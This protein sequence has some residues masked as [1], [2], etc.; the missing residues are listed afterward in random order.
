MYICT[1]NEQANVI[2]CNLRNVMLLCALSSKV[3]Y[4][5]IFNIRNEI[6]P[7]Q[8]CLFVRALYQIDIPR[9]MQLANEIF[10]THF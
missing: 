5:K 7:I 3:S 8:L 9:A 4:N 2:K 10:I 1:R 6:S